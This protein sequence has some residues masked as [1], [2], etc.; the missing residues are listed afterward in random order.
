MAMGKDYK[1]PRGLARKKAG[2]RGQAAVLLP[3]PGVLCGP[4]HSLA[5]AFSGRE[6]F[7]MRLFRGA[8]LLLLI[9]GPGWAG[10]PDGPLLSWRGFLLPEPENRQASA[11]PAESPPPMALLAFTLR[12]P[13]GTYLYGPE[14]TEGLPTTVSVSVAPISPFAAGA[15]LARPAF[16]ALLREKGLPAPVLLP[17]ATPKKETVFASVLPPGMPESDTPIFAGPVTFWAEV[18]SFAPFYGSAALRAKVAGLLCSE[19]SCTPLEIVQDLVLDPAALRAFAPAAAQNWWPE[20]LKG[21]IV[22]LPLQESGF[23]REYSAAAEYSSG[24][25]AGGNPPALD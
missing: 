24:F 8:L 18:P 1:A 9:C 23:G 2:R 14:T 3:E 4:A 10:Q 25:L 13:S 15:P 5:R 7:R 12:P 11:L 20:F 17:R 22:Q 19:T 21:S 16:E 6:V